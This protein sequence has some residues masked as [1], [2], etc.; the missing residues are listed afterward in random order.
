M[1]RFQKV[2]YFIID[3]IAGGRLG[4]AP[5]KLADDKVEFVKIDALLNDVKE[6][7]PETGTGTACGG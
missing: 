6:F 4:T 1:T 7:N 5:V 2:Q 3:S